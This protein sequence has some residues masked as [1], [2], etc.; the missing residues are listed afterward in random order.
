ML[1]SACRIHGEHP[2]P[3]LHQFG[4][5]NA[6][7]LDCVLEGP[8]NYCMLQRIN[9][10]EEQHRGRAR[11]QLWSARCCGFERGCHLAQADAAGRGQAAAHQ[12]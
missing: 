6:C 7:T 8:S 3:V 5:V 4:G 9:C 11:L 1:R 12:Q 2:G 10:L